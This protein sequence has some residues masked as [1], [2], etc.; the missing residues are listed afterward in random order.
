MTALAWRTAR[1]HP[2]SLGGAFLTLALG[3]ALLSAL[4][5][6]LA[7]AAGA[8]ASSRWFTT[9]EVVVAGVDTVNATSGSG[10]D[11]QTS[12]ITTGQARAVPV[13]LALRLTRLGAAAVTDYAG[14]AYLPGAPGDTMHPW[15]AAALHRFTWMAGCPPAGTGQIALTAP[16]RYRPGDQVNVQ[17]AAGWRRF[18]V[19]GVIRT[20]AGPALYS[21]TA[22][23]SAVAG[24]RI[25]AV[26][27]TA[28]SRGTAAALAARART[29]AKGQPVRVLTG[30]RRQD[31]IPSPSAALLE[32]TLSLLAITLSVAGFVS[33]TV[34]AGTFGYAV[35]AR[36]RELG[37]LRA[38]GATPRQARR[39]ILGEALAVSLLAAPAGSAAGMALA[40]PWAR[41]LGRSGLAPVGFTAHLAVWPPLTAAAAGV[42]IALA[43]AWPGARRAGRVRPAEAMREAEVDG[44]VMTLPRWAGGLAAL[45][46]A[47]PVIWVSANIHSA[48]TSAVFVAVAALLI[49]GCWLLAPSWCAPWPGCSGWP[50]AAA[51]GCSPGQARRSQSGGRWPPSHRSWSPSAWPAPGWPARTPSAPPSRLPP[52]TGS[53]PPR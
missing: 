46:G 18:L 39:L 19:S 11:Q 51:Q 22:V 30:A 17:T 3:T 35:A 12:T 7:S 50:R 42:L 23:A 33:V 41:W 1:S 49:T 36:R 44:G 48:D 24:G 27:L 47:V 20:A 21:T 5:L 9:P 32:G 52:G 28:R 13:G 10:A 43:G 6:T 26:A 34:I 2:A 15:A 45:A 53:P 14:Y 31:A 29:L 40:P 8:A 4:I 37:L 38:A 25:S 16:T